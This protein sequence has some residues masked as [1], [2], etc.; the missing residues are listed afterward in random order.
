MRPSRRPLRAAPL[1]ALALGGCSLGGDDPAP[2]PVKGAPR[3]VARVVAELDRATRRDQYRRI[4]EELLTS[5]ARRRAGGRDCPSLLRST[6]RDL[7]NPSVELVSIHVTSRDAIAR[8]RT[9]ATGQ[10]PIVDV[11]VLRREGGRYRIEALT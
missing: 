6:A 11:L 2:A 7:R 4:C 8:V 9:R 1:V 3:D 5:A 10:A